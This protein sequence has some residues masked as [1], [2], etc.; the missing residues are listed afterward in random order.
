MAETIDLRFKAEIR[1]S[2]T[3]SILRNDLDGNGEMS[4]EEIDRVRAVLSGEQRSRFE[5]TV[6]KVDT[7]N[8]GTLSAA[9]I[10][11]RGAEAVADLQKLGG[12]GRL[13]GTA[14]MVFDANAD[15]VVVVDDIIKT[16]D[17]LTK[18][19]PSV[20]P[21]SRSDRN[22]VCKLPKP[23]PEASPVF[24]GAYE[25]TALS[26]VAVAGPENET[27]FAELE[28]EEGK[29]PVYI[30]ASVYDAMVLRVTGATERVERFVGRSQNGMG[31]IGLPAELVDLTSLSNCHFPV[32][33]KEN[34]SKWIKARALL[35]ADLGREASMIVGYKL[36]RLQLPSGRSD[37]PA[38]SQK[39]SGGIIIQK[40]DKRFRMTDKGLA[41]IVE[42]QTSSA[43]EIDL[44][45]NYPDG[46]ERLMP[47][48][49]VT[50][51]KAEVY[52]V[53]PQQAGLVQLMKSG[54]LSRLSDGA[55]S[56]DKPIVR[57]PA[58]LNGGHSVKFVLRSG[59]PMPAGSR[60]HSTVLIE[61]TGECLG[62]RC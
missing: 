26:T 61:E 48:D 32:A 6:I 31:V 15:D 30:V 22:E 33:Y 9:E 59:V 12:R 23:S 21:E 36:S 57:F 11:K 37:K 56:I 54:A 29:E 35:T 39:A 24:V 49:I 47:E 62:I 1:T 7:D 43:L 25:G 53:L 41:E 55:Y 42:S 5:T 3:T 4:S 60:G 46:I 51:G 28:I 18:E 58:G 13:K 45:R 16:I 17:R 27:T 34:T 50:N 40:G 38:A 52:E 10:R 2:I 8:D 14:F 19:G 44:R 20:T